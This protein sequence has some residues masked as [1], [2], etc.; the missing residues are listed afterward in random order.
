MPDREDLEDVGA[1]SHLDPDVI[2]QLQQRQRHLLENT[3]ELL[4]VCSVHL[5]RLVSSS[6]RH[7]GLSK[8]ACVYVSEWTLYKELKRWMAS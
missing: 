1:D 6:V 8:F 2:R 5:L 3:L 7:C 4:E